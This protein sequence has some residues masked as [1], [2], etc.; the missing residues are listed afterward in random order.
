MDMLLFRHAALSFSGE[1]KLDSSQQFALAKT[2]LSASL[3]ASSSQAVLVEVAQGMFSAALLH[4]CSQVR[5]MS[6]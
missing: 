4:P 2:L 6:S 5:P 3:K 1:L